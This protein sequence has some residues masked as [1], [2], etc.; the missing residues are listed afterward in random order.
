LVDEPVDGGFELEVAAGGLE[1][2]HQIGSEGEEDAPA[3]FDERQTKSCRQM[4]LA[5]GADGSPRCR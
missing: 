3:V 4:R 1:P 5:A 2:L